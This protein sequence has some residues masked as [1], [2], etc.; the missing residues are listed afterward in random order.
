MVGMSDDSF[1]VVGT[2]TTGVGSGGDS[3]PTTGW[4]ATHP[5]AWPRA[6]PTAAP[7]D[8]GFGQV[9]S[10]SVHAPSDGSLWWCVTTGT[11][12]VWRMLAA[13]ESV[14]A[15][16]PVTPTRVYDSGRRTRAVGDPRRGQL[17]GYQRRQRPEPDHRGHHGAQP[18]A[19]CCARGCHQ[20]HGGRWH[21]DGDGG[22][23]AGW[24]AHLPAS[25]VNFVAGQ[26]IANGLTV[27]INPASRT[28]RAFAITASVHVIVDVT[29]YFR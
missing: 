20:P 16:V 23:G 19:G 17:A 1:G 22:A 25:A 4:W 10:R 28:L 9:G 6:S 2:S 29:G 5:R 27:A 11:P 26:R 3:D 18:G 15:F 8:P 14:G 12:G 13:P 24:H 7:P 21:R